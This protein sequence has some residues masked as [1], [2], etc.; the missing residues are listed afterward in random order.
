MVQ[1]R[2]CCP[3]S[4]LLCKHDLNLIVVPGYLKGYVRRFAQASHD[5]RGTPEV[6]NF[7][8]LVIVKCRSNVIQKPGRVVTLVH[9]EEWDKYSGAVSNFRDRQAELYSYRNTGCFP[10]WRYCVGCVCLRLFYSIGICYQ[11]SIG[12]AYTIDPVYEA[13]VRDYLGMWNLIMSFAHLLISF[14]IY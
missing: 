4:K 2:E 13:E 5:H 14:L 12:I 10:R 11:Q 1:Q 6:C 7:Y 8:S 3:R 9:K